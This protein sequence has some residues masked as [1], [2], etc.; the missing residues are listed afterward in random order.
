MTTLVVLGALCAVAGTIVA[1]LPRVGPS[2]EAAVVA[3]VVG[4]ALLGACAAVPG[5]PVGAG[6]GGDDLR[7]LLPV[8]VSLVGVLGG[9]PVTAGVLRLADREVDGTTDLAGAAAVLRG[10]AW[11]G[12]FERAAVFATLV[13]GWPE[14]I[15]VVLAVK[16]LGRYSELRGDVP[17]TG[18][19]SDSGGVAERFIIGTFSSTL[20]AA[21]AAG[22]L[23]GLLG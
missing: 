1:W 23:A 10:G 21:G 5:A 7:L 13:A 8:G 12:V 11:I 15:A 6:A 20:W 22:V 19:V 9:G 2:T 3:T 14:G 16:G 4:A 18:T 17:G